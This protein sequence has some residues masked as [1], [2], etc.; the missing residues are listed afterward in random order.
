[1]EKFSYEENGYNKEEVNQF[2]SDVIKETELV[3]SRVKSQNIEIEK[4]KSELSYYKE[5]E[6]VLSS[7]FDKAQEW[8]NEIKKVAE[9]EGEIIISDAKNNASVIVNEALL[10]AEQIEKNIL[11]LENKIKLLKTKL[12][13][14]L[15]Q[16]NVMMNEINN[17][18]IDDD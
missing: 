9:K 15:E 18:N 4:L 10:R 8:G 16:Q 17:L 14:F 12:N 13:I 7:S 5:L 2:I 1:M 6:N 3:V 11:I